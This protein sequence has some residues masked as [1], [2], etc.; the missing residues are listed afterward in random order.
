MAALPFEPLGALRVSL[1]AAF[2]VLALLFLREM[3]RH[4]DQGFNPAT[5]AL[6]LL[7]LLTGISY[8]LSYILIHKFP[9]SDLQQLAQQ[10]T[11]EAGFPF[12]VVSSLIGLGTIVPAAALLI[13]V[14]RY[15][16]IVGGPYAL[17]ESRDRLKV[18]NVQMETLQ[19]ITSEAN[20][21]LQPKELSGRVAERLRQA[22]GAD[23]V[24]L[25]LRR[26]D[27]ERMTLLAVAGVAPATLEGLEEIGP[28]DAPLLWSVMGKDTAVPFTGAA[29]LSPTAA[30]VGAPYL[31]A[32]PLQAKGRAIGVLGV[33]SKGPPRFLRE[34]L[35]LVT[36]VG[37]T[38]GVALENAELYQEAIAA[39]QRSEFLMDTISH[40]L[41]NY[42]VAAYGMVELAAEEPALTPEG[43]GYLQRALDSLGDISDLIE[44]VRRLAKIGYKTDLNL[45]PVDLRE[46]VERSLK[47]TREVYPEKEVVLLWQSDGLE[48]P[49]LG[50]EFLG[51]LVLNL[52]TN[53]VKYSPGKL[54]TI[55]V[56]VEEL[57]EGPRNFLRLSVADRGLGIPDARKEKIFQRFTK[58]ARGFGM[59]LSIVKAIADRYGGRVWVE[60]RVKGDYTQG[61]VFRVLLPQ[62]SD[63]QG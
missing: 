56:D 15:D 7:F 58:G 54:V 55:D 24:V 50:D 8:V 47:S 23:A 9:T 30:R 32:A 60:D 12:V 63:G 25:Y 49:V 43:R 40:D 51:Q 18:R 13:L 20:Q 22:L 33:Y 46:V 42:N 31:I 26:G 52:L 48:P 34:E 59:G 61:S 17:V 35:E 27:Q 37:N 41:R 19:E 57:R 14:R 44:N 3:L 6:F 38:V 2:L 4:R 62:A 16:L 10:I 28:Q 1:A 11:L 21:S 39:R 5:I 53:A 29:G 36:S 45:K